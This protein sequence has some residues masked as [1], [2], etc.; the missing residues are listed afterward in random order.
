MMRM[1]KE[2]G[3][4]NGMKIGRANRRTWRKPALE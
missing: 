1:I 3:A 2:Y 4:V